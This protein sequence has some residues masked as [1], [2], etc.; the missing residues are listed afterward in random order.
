MADQSLQ[1]QLSEHT[2]QGIALTQQQKTMHVTL[3]TPHL[4]RICFRQFAPL[5]QRSWSVVPEDHTWSLFDWTM[6]QDDNY[7]SVDT[8]QFQLQINLNTGE[9]NGLTPENIVFCADQQPAS[10]SKTGCTVHKKMMPQE[11]FYGFGERTGWLEKSG[12]QYLNW[13]YDP[14]HTHTA[15]VNNMYAAMP[16]Y[17]AMQAN[18]TYG[19]FLNSTYRSTFDIGAIMPEQIIWN[20]DA[21][22]LD[23]FIAFGPTPADVTHCWRELLGATPLPPMWSLG[24]HQSRWGYDSAQTMR[25]IASQL[26]QHAIPCDAL[27]FDIDYMNEYRVFTWHPDRFADPKLLID[28]L[29]ND[30]INVV[31]IIDPGVK[32]DPHYHV[33]QDGLAR[34]MFIRRADGSVF[35]GYVWPDDSVFAD[36]TRPDVR[37]WWG[38]LHHVLLD[39]GVR[40]IWND[41]NEPTVFARPFSEGGGEAGTIDLDAPQGE[42]HE[43]TTHAEVHNLYGSLMAQATYEGLVKLRPNERPFILTRSAFAG[44]Q[45]WATLWTGDN[46]AIWEHL[47]MT[48]P[49]MCNLGLSGV[50]FCG[51]DIGGFFG[52]AT[53][54]LWARWV[55]V[56]ALLPFC[57]GHSCAGTRNA[58]PWEFGERT[59]GI[60]RAYLTLRYRLLPYIYTLFHH[61]ST[62][63]APIIRPLVYEFPRDSATHYLHDQ[64]ML[65]DWLMFAPIVRPGV[66][67]RAV[68]LPEGE[69]YDW[70]TG[71]R[72]RGNQHLLVHAPLE[73]LPLYVR[74]GAILPLAPAMD[75]TDIT[76]WN[77]LTLDVYPSGE[78]SW[79]FYEDDGI[80]FEYQHGAATWTEFHCSETAHEIKL[81]IAPQASSWQPAP[82]MFVINVHCRV[83][84][85]V[86][87]DDEP[88][89]A[90]VYA[91]NAVTLEMPDDRAHHTLMIELT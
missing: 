86:L 32:N 51:V 41:M 55:Q 70:W 20:T 23:Y 13:T 62:T 64:A 43:R 89:S 28:D 4:V 53:P 38:E 16:I 30:G 54:E 33:Q 90:W 8:G 79:A 44:I 39:A 29:R 73:R 48:L 77:P 81:I 59:L 12:S 25:Q 72:I 83:P 42:E 66:E 9:I 84:Q 60:A 27:H 46:S 74:G 63:G 11:R 14:E 40:G 45:R 57:R 5:S 36:F 87:V 10:I 65:G 75:R 61:A 68:Y 49:Q 56:G 67:H 91:E 69:W 82:R 80:S 34:D 3:C 19:V 50:P 7:L 85:R 78:S 26:R 18:F 2:A 88:T 47:E 71:D 31:T 24:Y 76:A 6:N 37:T 52:N 58:E 22:E 15:R 21:P 35:S 17:V 1:W